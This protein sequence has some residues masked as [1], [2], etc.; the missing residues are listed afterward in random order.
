M[1]PSLDTSKFDENE[2]EFLG[3]TLERQIFGALYSA[4]QDRKDCLGLT[5]AEFGRRI[6]RDKTGVSKL[7][8]GPGNWTIRTISDFANALD[9]DVEIT[10]VDRRDVNR[11]FTPFGFVEFPAAPQNYYYSGMMIEP[12]AAGHYSAV[13]QTAGSAQINLTPLESK[14]AIY[15]LSSNNVVATGSY[16]SQLTE[17]TSPFNDWAQRGHGSG[18]YIR[19]LGNWSR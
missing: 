8:R 5:R 15:A 4:V 1:P 13:I 18:V 9:L 3:L 17:I 14:T 19:D 10:F 12:I 16:M 11:V 2:R 7:L 6:G